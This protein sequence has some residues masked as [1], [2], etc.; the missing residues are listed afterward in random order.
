[1]KKSLWRVRCWPVMAAAGALLVGLGA[2]EG[3][4]AQAIGGLCNGRPATRTWL[5]PGSDKSIGIQRAV[6]GSV[7][8]QGESVR[9]T[10]R[11]GVAHSN[12]VK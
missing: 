11:L 12:K 9:W 5:D 3:G 2:V 10:L 6:L 8:S 1:M 7:L 4:G